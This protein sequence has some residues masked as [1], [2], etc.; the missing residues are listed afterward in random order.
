MGYPSAYRG[1]VLALLFL[2]GIVSRAQAQTI[3]GTIS[4]SVTIVENGLPGITVGS[5]VSGTYS[6]DASV[7]QTDEYNWIANPLSSLS[8]T[9]G[10]FPHVFTLGDVEN[11]KYG[12][13]R[14]VQ[15]STPS[16]DALSIIFSYNTVTTYF[17]D[18]AVTPVGSQQGKLT[19]VEYYLLDVINQQTN[20]VVT[21]LRFDFLAT[22]N[23]TPVP[24][25]GSVALLAGLGLSGAGFLVRRRRNARQ[26]A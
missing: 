7:F 24:E 4:G 3:T 21:A 23:V 18:P 14:V 8:L 2:L 22:P 15:F 9:L 26:A 16:T 12:Y 10:N 17:V 1:G 6:D 13:E 20:S 5:P 19:P 25:P 11:A